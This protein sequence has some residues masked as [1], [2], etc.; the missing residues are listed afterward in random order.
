M[1]LAEHFYSINYFKT[2]RLVELTWLPG[3]RQMTDQDFKESLCVFAEGALQHR[4]KRLII[5]MRQ[6]MS[7]PSAEIG[8]W[9]D[10]VIVPR[11]MHSAG[12]KKARSAGCSNYVSKAPQPHVNY[13]QKSGNTRPKP[14]I[15]CCSALVR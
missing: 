3:T 15:Y 13:W 4:A 9:R 6:F 2:E 5:D 12:E 8:T 11:L 14:S 1:T 7:Q 10:E